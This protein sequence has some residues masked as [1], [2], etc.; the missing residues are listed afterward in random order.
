MLYVV[1]LLSF[2]KDF[3][4][5]NMHLFFYYQYVIEKY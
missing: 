5:K 3:L 4:Y 2:E 1:T